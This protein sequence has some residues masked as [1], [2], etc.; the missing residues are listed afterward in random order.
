MLCIKHTFHGEYNISPDYTPNQDLRHFRG[1]KIINSLARSS[2]RLLITN[3]CSVPNKILGSWVILKVL[4][5]FVQVIR[6]LTSSRHFDG[7]VVS[8]L[9]LSISFWPGPRLLDQGGLC[10]WHRPETIRTRPL[11]CWS[12]KWTIKERDPRYL[13][14]TDSGIAIYICVL[15]IY[16]ARNF[17]YIDPSIRVA[18]RRQ[19]IMWPKLI[20]IWRQVKSVILVSSYVQISGKACPQS[21]RRARA[22]NNWNNEKRSFLWDPLWPLIYGKQLTIWLGDLSNQSGMKMKL[23][24]DVMTRLEKYVC[25]Y[26][27]VCMYQ[28]VCMYVC[29]YSMYVCMYVCFEY[30]FFKIF[31][32]KPLKYY[33]LKDRQVC[34][35]T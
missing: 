13:F 33:Y 34:F 10:A 9:S 2:P 31:A 18:P 8:R 16:G 32:R 12:Q 24:S 1:W 35:L 21:L 28:Y 25:M 22:R 11:S 5:H 20:A 30:L 15:K 17:F 6:V 19:M 14:E 27:Y 7:T 26:W 29:M 3:L 4:S 23:S